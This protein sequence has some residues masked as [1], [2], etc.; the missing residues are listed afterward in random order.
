MDE[1][2]VMIVQEVAAMHGE[3]ADFVSWIIRDGVVGPYS[4]DGSLSAFIDNLKISCM[5]VENLGYGGA[6]RFE[7]SWLVVDMSYPRFVIAIEDTYSDD[8]LYI[9][10]RKG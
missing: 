9:F 4:C 10:I 6:L 1:R 7:S 2:F 3:R 5:L 8:A